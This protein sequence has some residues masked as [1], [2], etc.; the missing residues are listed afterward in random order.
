[1]SGTRPRLVSV[2]WPL[3]AEMVLGFGVGMLG[4]WLASHES[5]TASA[6]FG[7]ANHLQNAFFLLF[8]IVSMGVSVVITQNIGAGN[9]AQA[10]LTARASMGASTWLGLGSG[11][12]VLWAAGPLLA[13]LHAP[14]EV[15]DVG[16]PYLQML[17]LAL[18]LDAW[19][20]SMSSV[21]RAH[22]RTREVM[23]NILA[24]HVLHLLLCLPF[25]RGFGP[26]PPLGLVG[27]ALAMTVSRVLG[28]AVHLALWR[29]Q[30]RL[31]PTWRDWWAMRWKT[32]APVMHIGLPGAAENMAYR[33]AMLVSVAIVAD[34][35]AK[36]LATHSYTFQIMNTMVLFTASLAF[37]A[38][39]LVGHLVGGG[40]FRHASNLV[41]KCLWWGLG[42]STCIAIA[43]A[44]TS[45]WTM[46]IFTQDP[47]II[48]SATTL[49]WITVLLEPGRTCNIVLINALRATGDARF[50]V[51]VGAVSMLIIMAG[52][53]WLLGVYFGLGL[54]GV[55]IAYAA[56]EG[57]R[58][59]IMARRW[60]GLKWMPAA[61]TSRGRVARS[62]RSARPANRVQHLV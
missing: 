48:H 25:M 44:A 21:M 47:E 10:D 22:L 42:V 2:T 1:L 46:R 53:S 17:A 61:R 15:V 14:V 29:G 39:I 8:R 16:R 58:G 45:P 57:V 20:A 55:W 36:S 43:V 35:G 24:M 9:R 49:L 38:E 62:H 30:L 18:V 19:N 11:I 4:L 51:M 34:L 12:V 33:A 5:D 6:A 50:P 59:L 26:I 32:L 27:F 23:L 31:V 13:M 52:G 37:A 40:H 28:L 54:V 56:D 3:L 41:R 7:L 60:F